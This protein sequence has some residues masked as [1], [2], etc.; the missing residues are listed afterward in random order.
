MSKRTSRTVP[1][2]RIED[3]PHFTNEAEER[4]FWDTH[5]LTEEFW[6]TAPVPKESIAQ[7]ARRRAEELATK[8]D[9]PAQP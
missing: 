9:T 2:R 8:H 7:R 1:V 4:A 6:D 3:I 5:C